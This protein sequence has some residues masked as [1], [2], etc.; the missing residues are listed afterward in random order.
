MFELLVI[1][2]V[3]FIYLGL[4]SFASHG[5]IQSTIESDCESPTLSTP[6]FPAT[7]ERSNDALVDA[8][9]RVNRMVG[10]QEVIAQRLVEYERNRY[11]QLAELELVHPAIDRWIR[12]NGS[13][14]PR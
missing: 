12:Y 14:I 7:K 3:I 8:L 6:S 10:H 1:V 2:A 13:V 11:P 9:A 5:G 4:S